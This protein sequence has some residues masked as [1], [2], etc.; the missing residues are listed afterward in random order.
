M[1]GFGEEAAWLRHGLNQQMIV[2]GFLR[3]KD[4]PPH[5]I[6][7]FLP[8]FMRPQKI[9]TGKGATEEEYLKFQMKSKKIEAEVRA[10]HKRIKE[11]KLKKLREER[12]TKKVKNLKG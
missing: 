12:R 1:E 10:K 11:E 6:E 8:K 4:A 3:G 9:S 5:K 7:D 2:N